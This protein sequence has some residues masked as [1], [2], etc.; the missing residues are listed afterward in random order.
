MTIKNDQSTAHRVLFYQT[1]TCLTPVPRLLTP[2]LP[3]PLAL[4]LR[5][6]FTDRCKQDNTQATAIY[7]CLELASNS[8]PN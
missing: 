8:A 7:T 4:T 6:A 3:L 2:Q 5:S 1:V